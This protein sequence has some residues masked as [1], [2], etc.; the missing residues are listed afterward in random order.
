MNNIK[1]KEID[2][3]VIQLLLHRQKGVKFSDIKR[4]IRK[5][6]STTVLSLRRLERSKF[7]IKKEALYYLSLD[8]RQLAK[9]KRGDFPSYIR[10]IQSSKTKQK[11]SNTIKQ[12]WKRYKAKERNS[13]IIFFILRLAASGVNFTGYIPPNFKK[14]NLLPPDAWYSPL[15]ETVPGVAV[16]DFFIGD[17]RDFATGTLKGL[18]FGKTE[19]KTCIEGLVTK[20]ILK[21][22]Y[23]PNIE[24]TTNTN[25][26]KQ[27]YEIVDKLLKEFIADIQSLLFDILEYWIKEVWQY[28]RPK[29][30]ES[31]WYEY[32]TSNMSY[33]LG[34]TYTSIIRDMLTNNQ[35]DKE[36]QRFVSNH[37]IKRDRQYI[38]EYLQSRRRTIAETINRKW[39]TIENK[40][41]VVQTNNPGIYKLLTE[42]AYPD[43]MRKYVSKYI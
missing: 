3:A 36:I 29:G 32:I 35:R 27:R 26:E 17:R 33:G 28:E 21:P 34:L 8:G 43:F 25:P 31:R 15:I 2:K 18:G 10:V 38:I 13:Q 1:R 23:V 39:E 16:E 42:K 6:P 19:I 41:G 11:I 5:H 40:Y 9:E 22:L 12:K 14:A 24:R 20:S 7:V 4:G 37:L 30:E